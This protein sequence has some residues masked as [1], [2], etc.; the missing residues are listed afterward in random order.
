LKKKK[1]RSLDSVKTRNVD[2][3]IAF[4]GS[5]TRFSYLLG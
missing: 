5:G 4:T 1:K 2:M 3:E